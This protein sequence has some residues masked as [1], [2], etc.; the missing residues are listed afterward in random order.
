MHVIRPADMPLLSP[1]HTAQALA[2]LPDAALEIDLS[3]A[4]VAANDR[5]LG[6]FG[7]THDEVVGRPLD[8]LVDLEAVLDEMREDAVAVR[9]GVKAQARRSSGVPFPVRASLRIVA[10]EAD[11]RAV[12]VLR[13]LD[14]GELAEMAQQ[15]FDVAFDSAPIGM[16]LF[17]SD[18]EYVRVN[19]ALCEMLGRSEDELLGRRDQELTHPADRQADLDAA[20]EILEGRRST[21]QCEKRFVRPDGSIV[22]AIASL[23]FLR[24]ENGGPLTWVGQFQDITSRR[25]AEG[26]L[27]RERDLSHAIIASMTD[28]FVLTRSGEVIM[29]NDALCRLTGFTRE[30]AVGSRMPYPWTPPEDH[31]QARE[32]AGRILEEGASE[33]DL[34]LMRKDGTRFHATLTSARADGPDGSTLGFVHT[35]RDISARKRHEDEL[36][37]RASSDGLTGLLNQT[38]LRDQLA[39][40]FRDATARGQRLSFALLDLDHFKRV[41]DT[42]GHPAGDRVLVEVAR[43]LQA[44]SRA[45]DH[46]ARVGGEEFAW[47]LRGSDGDDALAAVERARIAI[48]STPFGDAGAVTISAGVCDLAYAGDV[49][50]LYRLADIALYSAKARGRNVS[51]PYV[52]N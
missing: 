20:W 9:E 13:E 42:H 10:P 5:A 46:V 49:D 31:A 29:V 38:A 3:G 30:D 15:Y 34:T 25:A 41:N 7:H 12:C 6:M 52:A 14:R 17:N 40:E 43:R 35:F 32:I 36:A 37:R 21:F 23:T 45:G 44:V 16:A 33:L 4:V 19:S 11:A 8:E 48:E 24:D 28:A 51:V 39:E 22:W 2:L 26:A 47:I 27:R 50:Q 1:S 18:G